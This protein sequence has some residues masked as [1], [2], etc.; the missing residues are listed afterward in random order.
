MPLLQWVWG[1]PL[2]AEWRPASGVKQGVQKISG[3]FFASPAKHP[4][5]LLGRDPVKF[6][7]HH[8]VKTLN[9]V[10]NMAG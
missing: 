2:K 8:N 9:D 6:L 10:D 7:G 1:A 3:S 4:P 5:L